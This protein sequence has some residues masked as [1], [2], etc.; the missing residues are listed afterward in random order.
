MRKKQ[1]ALAGLILALALLVNLA[2]PSWAAEAGSLDR[3]A[4]RAAAYIRKSVTNPQVGSIGGEWAVI[5]LARSGQEVP[6]TYWD[7]YYRTVEEYVKA[8]GGVLHAKKYTEYSRVVLA[9]T[10]IGA[11]PR[12]VAG[13]DLLKP[14][15]DYDR[16]IWQGING[17]IWALIAL[18]SGNYDVPANPE[19]T[20]Q[21]TRQRYVDRILACQLDGG[22]W[23]LTAQG[24]AGTG[25]P[26]ITGMALQ[27]LARYREQPAVE[28]AI[29]RALTC[30][31][32]MQD[33]AGGYASWG[34]T[35]SESV[36][37]VLVALCGLGIPLDDPRFVKNGCTLLD[38][39]LSYQQ[40]DGSFLH[41]GAGNGSN[42]MASEQGF[43]GLAAALRARDGRSALYRMDDVTIHVT[44]GG[45]T[46]GLPGKHEAVRKQPVTDPGRTF[47]D[48]S[49][50]SAHPNQ[51]AIEALASRGLLSGRGTG[52]FDPDAGMTRA[53]FSA[54][55]VR[56]LGLTPE[57]GG[58]FSDVPPSA[59]YAPFVGTA[60]RFGIIS[61]VGDGKFNP[62]GPITRQEAAVMVTRAAA[63][64]GL[65]TERGTAAVRDTLA[66]FGDYVTAAPWARPGLAFC[67]DS[68][69]LD[70]A[71]LE[72]MPAQAI[73]RCEIAQMLFNL[74]GRAR[75]V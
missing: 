74:L 40:P 64:C 3:A 59:W 32:G 16:T 2:V 52:L 26:D 36:V 22:G 47:P 10:A 35:N 71:A 73:R 67:Y 23:N 49:G 25:D 4:A 21:A 31:S 8:C 61:G 34:S 20:T 37:Q 19:A 38:N 18:D 24:G 39:L 12:D 30:L 65:D 56:A 1:N 54:A 55:V 62:G 17:P 13:Y 14:L 48:I 46:A 69:I 60:S 70:S 68:G 50:E 51:A 5:G 6:Q 41:T 43:Y 33:A 72:I 75:L 9:L 15:G 29:Q 45:G 42:Q 44:N 53:E 63:L 58:G 27:A 7:T 66:Q 57:A 11:D 28:T